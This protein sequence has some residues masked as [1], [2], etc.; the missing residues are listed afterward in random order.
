MK[1]CTYCKKEKITLEIA[2]CKFCNKDQCLTHIIPE[3]HNCSGLTQYKSKKH[4]KVE[5]LKDNPLYMSDYRQLSD[6]EKV[7]KLRDK[8]E[9]REDAREERSKLNKF[10]LPKIVFNYF[11]DRLLLIRNYLGL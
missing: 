7:R 8:R 1:K 5:R 11:R 2:T 3:E 4:P 10:P 9:R 6:F